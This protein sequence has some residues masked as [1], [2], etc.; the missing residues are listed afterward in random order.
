MAT[1]RA[2]G[3]LQSLFKGAL[4][5]GT[6]P[7]DGQLL[8]AF[9]ARGDASAFEAL[10]RRHGP[11]V[12]G[13]CRRVLRN[14]ADAEDAFQATF[15]VLLRKATAIGR[16]ELLANWL[17]GVAYRTALEAKAA[18]ARR[19]LKEGQVRRAPRVEADD[20][21][22]WQ[23]LRPFLDRELSRLPDKYRVPIVLCDLEGKTRREAA[24]QLGWPE[25][26][27]SGR[28]SRARALL[29]KR[30]QR[31]G[32]ALSAGAVAVLIQEAAPAAMPALPVG[33]IVR[34]AA[35]VAA[36]RATTG[37][38]SDRVV[39]LTTRVMKTM[40]L[41]KLKTRLVLLA[42]AILLGP[43]A[44]TLA[45]LT[46]SGAALADPPE[47]GKKP[48]PEAP[49]P[50]R[51]PQPPGV[52]F[53]TAQGF[54]WF[55]VPRAGRG[56]FWSIG[57][58]PKFPAAADGVAVIEEKD[59]D[60]ALLLTL[61]YSAAAGKD[62]LERLRPVAFDAKRERYPL[63]LKYGG[64]AGSVAMYRYH[65]DAK[66]LPAEQVAALGIEQLD[67]DGLKTLARRAAE[68]AAKQ[69]IPV[70]GF[71]ELDKPFRFTLTT[72]DGKRIDARDLRGKVILIDCWASWCSPCMEMQPKIK[73]L[74][75]KWH[76]DGLEVVGF[77]F[78]VDSNAV[79]K[80]CDKLGLTWPQVI[81]PREKKATLTGQAETGIRRLPGE[82]AFDPE[83]ILREDPARIWQEATGIGVLPRLLLI[84]RAGILRADDPKDLA[85]AVAALMKGS[86]GPKK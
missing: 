42:A 57:S 26:T 32:P 17:Y 64:R 72:M 15:L 38:V 28:L 24:E 79:K 11:L 22:V 44:A 33:A 36:G 10:V 80:V 30:L 53:K 35:A 51:P 61:S 21:E 76:K 20:E 37:A 48:T 16:R 3:L 83:G 46:G 23:E 74:Y 49:A 18:S 4:G 41:T 14:V 50:A 66:K 71:P 59:K 54:S 25:G 45:Y 47:P 31:Y 34:A 1:V 63:Q 75:E 2:G 8:E 52:D 67:P 85:E 12:Y 86:P 13:V 39:A 69:G 9:L 40:L 55:V 65:L 29:A 73:D 82:L 19:R 58:V 5:A 60:G 56:Y 62:G 77:N 84:D 70:P 6:G 7:S 78:D 68:V 81:V 27:V 43:G